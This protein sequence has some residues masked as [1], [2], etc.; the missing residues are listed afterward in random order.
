MQ[1]SNIQYTVQ[2]LIMVYNIADHNLAS[3][4]ECGSSHD[5]FNTHTRPTPTR[6]LEEFSSCK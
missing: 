1:N 4:D 6:G 2:S 3:L 5:C